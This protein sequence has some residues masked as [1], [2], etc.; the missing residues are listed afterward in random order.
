MLLLA[1]TGISAATSDVVDGGI[2][3]TSGPKSLPARAVRTDD[4]SMDDEPRQCPYCDLHFDYH[5]EI[6][7]HVVRDHP[8]H[9][10]VVA[11]VELHE[12]PRH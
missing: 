12:L 10:E 3:A 4:E 7:D 8:E 6:L 9:A 5:N 1:A 2:I 11:G